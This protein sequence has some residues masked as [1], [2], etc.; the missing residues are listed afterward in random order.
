MS[1]TPFPALDALM[2]AE[3]PLTADEARGVS[4]TSDPRTA[5]SPW[6]V[7]VATGMLVLLGAAHIAYADGRLSRTTA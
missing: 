7:A 4:R 6:L 3:L 2:G 5:G 1:T